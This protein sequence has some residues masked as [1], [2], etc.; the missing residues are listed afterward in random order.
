MS[1]N[2]FELDGRARKT[3]RIVQAIDAETEG[4]APTEV[5][6]CLSKL[7]DREWKRIASAAGANP[8]SIETRAQVIARFITRAKEDTEEQHPC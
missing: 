4:V 1:R 5:A 3:A 8:P 7:T 2:A 6:E